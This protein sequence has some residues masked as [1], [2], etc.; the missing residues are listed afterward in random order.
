ML[1]SQQ[2]PLLWSGLILGNGVNSV[3]QNVFRISGDAMLIWAYLARFLPIMVLVMIAQLRRIDTTLFDAARVLQ[4]SLLQRHIYVSLPLLAPG[5]LGAMGVMT[6]FSLGEL[7]T[8]LMVIPPGRTTIT[9]RIYNYLH[10][11]A[12]ESVAGLTLILMI[13]VVGM[14]GLTALFLQRST[15]LP[16]KSS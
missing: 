8:T 9:L 5:V 14:G 11:G 15:Q 1:F 3:S 12:S 10:Y 7:G 4:V 6:L 13:V 16:G 2:L